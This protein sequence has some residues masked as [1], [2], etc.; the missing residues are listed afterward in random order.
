MEYISD[1]ISGSKSLI[2]ITVLIISFSLVVIKVSSSKS[3]NTMF[4]AKSTAKNIVDYY[5][6]S[7][8]AFLKG[9]TYLVTGGN[10]GI[11]LETCKSL[12]SAGAKV[13]MCSRS[14]EAGLKSVEQEIKSSGVGG[15]S[16]IE[17]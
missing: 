9:K 3:F 12:L 17:N 2:T 4:N 1:Y 16:G 15:Y 5:S 14:V 11:G 6:G 8:P 10:S 7:N 13:I